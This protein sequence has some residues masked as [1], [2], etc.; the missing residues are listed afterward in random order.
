M[1]RSKF[2][3]IFIIS[4]VLLSIGQI[5]TLHNLSTLISSALLLLLAFFAYKGSI[6]ETPLFKFI[7][8]IYFLLA[9]AVIGTS[10][11]QLF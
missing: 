10:V 11:Y 9:L 6:R 1:K 2:I 3:L 7:S 4:S 5:L 8:V